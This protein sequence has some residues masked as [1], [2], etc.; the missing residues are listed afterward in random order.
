MRRFFTG[1]LCCCM[2]FL[3]PLSA[4]AFGEAPVHEILEEE[5]NLD[6]GG[7]VTLSV[8]LKQLP[9]G[10][11]S[12][13]LEIETVPASEEIGSAVFTSVNEKKIKVR[14][15]SDTLELD[16]ETA[17]DSILFSLCWTL[18]PDQTFTGAGIHLVLL[19]GSGQPAGRITLA[20]KGITEQPSAGEGSTASIRMLPRP[21]RVLHALLA[22]AAVIWVLALARILIR[23]KKSS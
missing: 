19:D 12:M 4:T 17:S 15:Q 21:D 16:P 8:R 6:S 10:I 5:W 3:L 20:A 2:I 22:A 18:P 14:K 13:K 11:S 23:K 9:D 7:A 1:F